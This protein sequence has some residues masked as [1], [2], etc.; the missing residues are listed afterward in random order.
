MLHYDILGTASDYRI[1]E[2][3]LDCIS[4]YKK[5]KIRKVNI[6]ST[7]KKGQVLE[8]VSTSGYTWTLSNIG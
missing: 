5:A 2:P 1:L 6:Y 4:G 7:G 3:F 8:I